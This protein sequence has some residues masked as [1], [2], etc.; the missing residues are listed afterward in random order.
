MVHC[1]VNM[2]RS[3]ARTTPR[4][5][6][7]D[8]T[9]DRITETAMRALARGG[10]DSLT[11]QKLATELGFAVGALYRY[12]PG[13]DGIIVAVQR[14]IIETIREELAAALK[15]TD[16]HLAHG[17]KL[18]SRRTALLRLWVM[19]QVYE[20]MARSRP[21]EFGLLSMTLGDPR[22]LVQ[23]VDA[24]QVVPPMVALFALVT[25]LFTAATDAGALAPGD[26]ARRTVV[27]WTS[28][29]GALQLR[30]LERFALGALDAAELLDEA[31]STL[32][33]GWGASPAEVKAMRTRAQRL[34]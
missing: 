24:S 23:D 13:K 7:R 29:H 10:L 6:K 11:M 27:L 9:F 15:R 31:V 34:R 22:Q 17:Q 1:T 16:E 8:V 28:V 25:E 4:Q 33:V 32:L 18:D 30:K 5:Q 12:F 2:I 20:A 14:R 21:T 3:L 26:P 19:A